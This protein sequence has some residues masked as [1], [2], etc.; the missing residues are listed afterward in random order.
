MKCRERSSLVQAHQPAASHE[1][2]A[3]ALTAR[4]LLKQQIY[5]SLLIFW[6]KGMLPR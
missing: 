4:G 3:A 2:L 1:S 5:L 6:Y